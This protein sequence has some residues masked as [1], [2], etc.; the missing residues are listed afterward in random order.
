MSRMLRKFIGNWRNELF[1]LGLGVGILV[2]TP[3]LL[4][5]QTCNSDA[6]HYHS[7]ADHCDSGGEGCTVVCPP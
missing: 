7:G 1:A 5:A 2:S 3:T 4:Q 6:N